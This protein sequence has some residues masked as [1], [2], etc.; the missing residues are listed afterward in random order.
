MGWPYH[1]VDLTK[2]QLHERRLL[3]DRY[4]I[5]SQLS[6]LIPIALYQLYRLS[7][8]VYKE[9]Q[10]SKVDYIAVPS[11]PDLK[12]RRTSTLGKVRAQWRSF[13]WWLGGDLIARYGKRGHWIATALWYSWLLFL[14]IHRTGDG[15]LAH[16][17]FVR[18][19]H[20]SY[21]FM[22]DC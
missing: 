22:M 9:R 5:Y 3:I 16:V 1:F 12:K 20:L 8:W 14:S 11:S 21:H 13:V 18:I 7:D 4:G 17:S 6:A 10:R 2:E 15:K 19:D